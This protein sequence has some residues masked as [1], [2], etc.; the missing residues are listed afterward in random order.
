MAP[1]YL[2]DLLTSCADAHDVNTRSVHDGELH[3]SRARTRAGESA[4]Y[5]RGPQ[6]YR[7]TLYHVIC[8]VLQI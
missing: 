5:I 6:T 2:K 8:T 7:R 1:D 4:F 3:V